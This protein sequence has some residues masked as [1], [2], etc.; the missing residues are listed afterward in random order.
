MR[1]LQHDFLGPGVVFP[2]APGFQIHRA[3]LPLLE[4]IVDAPQEAH[5]L[6][7]IRDREPVLDEV[8]TGAHQH[9]FE[10]RHGPEKLFVFLGRT[11]AH[12]LLDPGAVVPA[13]V[14]ADDFAG[15]RQVGRIAL[16]VPLGALALIGGRQGD[17]TADAGIEPLGDPLDRP[18]LARGIAALEQDHHLLARRHDPVLQLD[19]LGLQPEQ[20]RE[21][22]TA[23]GVFGRVGRPRGD[24]G[25]Q[26][27]AILDLHFELFVVTVG[28]IAAETTDE[29]LPVHGTQ[30][31]TCDNPA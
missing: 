20:L 28:E 1:A 2:A 10:I 30:I 8:N 12:H 7:L 26:V 29:V 17:H 14:E 15:C 6:L 5:M 13:A 27:I 11:E 23:V 4:R 19:Q 16:E 24:A 18:A 3:Q 31:R 22:L 9:A 25:R 21:V